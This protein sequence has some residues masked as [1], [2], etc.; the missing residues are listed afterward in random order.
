MKTTWGCVEFFSLA[1]SFLEVLVKKERR[2]GL[3]FRFQFFVFYLKQ[4]F[5]RPFSLMTDGQTAAIGRS[6]QYYQYPQLFSLH[7]NFE[8]FFHQCKH[9]TT[10]TLR[11]LAYL[12]CWAC[13]FTPNAS[14][15][16]NRTLALNCLLN[17]PG[18]ICSIRM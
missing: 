5:S 15:F 4:R 14:R 8:L 3:H 1:S 7:F 2:R 13:L 17:S 6:Y 11:L 12:S 9:K 16:R 18:D 10:Q